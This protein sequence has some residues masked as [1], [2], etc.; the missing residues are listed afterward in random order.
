[1][2]KGLTLILALLMALFTMTACGGQDSGSDQGEAPSIDTVKTFGDVMALDTEELQSAVGG[3]YVVYAFK[4]GDTY[5][6]AK[7]AISE[8]V[9][10]KYMDVDIF[11]EGYEKKQQK[12]IKNI[13]ID[14]MEDLSDQ[15]LSQDELDALAGKTGQELVDEGW[16][17]NGGHNLENME[18]WMGYG[19]FNY[20]V[21]FD[22]EVAESD[23]ETF[24]DEADTRE[25]TVRSAEFN[26]LGDATN[27]E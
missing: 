26:S 9:E 3:G 7:S 15:M 17:F 24:D 8:D 12:I 25:L 16:L 27:I 5:Y 10:Q 22:G 23:Y 21:F 18:F 20:S 1:M 19:P 4:Y 2:K 11:Q 14:E 6:R 13:E